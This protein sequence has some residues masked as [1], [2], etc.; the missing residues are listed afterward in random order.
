MSALMNVARSRVP[1][2]AE[3]AVERARLTVVPRGT[4]RAARVPFM[5]LVSV[6]LVGGIAGL[7]LFN[8]SMQQASFA[9][10]RL[11]Q[12]AAALL[13]QQQT[14]QMQ[15]EGDRDPQQVAMR[16]R[17]MG[18]VPPSTPAFLR[19]ADGKVL[20]DPQPA[21][22][23]DAVRI[24]PLPTRKPSNL[25]PVPVIVKPAKPEKPTAEDATAQKSRTDGAARR[26]AER[27]AGTKPAG[28]QTEQRQ[29]SGQGVRR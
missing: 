7:L 22:A 12:R 17:R 27:P 18:M 9:A 20:G 25:R 28:T 29:Q 14:L 16:A 26:D 3:A 1:R 10:A 13:S 2:I 6:L 11:E 23:A 21:T 19:L 5:T 8:T 15:L 24:A 4:T